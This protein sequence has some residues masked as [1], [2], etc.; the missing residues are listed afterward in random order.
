MIRERLAAGARRHA[1]PCLL[2]VDAR[3]REDDTLAGRAHGEPECESLRAD[4]GGLRGERGD[5][6]SAAVPVEEDRILD[7]LPREELLGEAGDEDDVE[8]EAARRLGGR[9]EDGAVAAPRGRPGQLAEPGTE[10]E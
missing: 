10:D 7:D 1:R 9:H 8:G 6:E 2:D 3:P 5:V 4:P